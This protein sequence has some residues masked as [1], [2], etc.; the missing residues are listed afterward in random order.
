MTRVSHALVATL[1]LALA[2]PL[3]AAAAPPSS[4]AKPVDLNDIRLPP[5]AKRLNKL[6]MDA[7]GAGDFETAYRE[8]KLSYASMDPRAD[9]DGRDMVLASL[10]SALVKLYEKTG[11]LQH[12]CL[13]RK[14][15]LLHLETL[16]VTFGED[17]DLQDIPGI[18]WRLR[19]I[20]EKISRHSPRLGEPTCN[21]PAIQIVRTAPPPRP[22][23]IIVP[24]PLPLN[25]RGRPALI[26]GATSLSV[27]GVL[28][29]AM[30]YA[31]FMRRASDEGIKAIGAA[32]TMQPDTLPT[33][34]QRALADS[35]AEV[36]RYH[37]TTA[38][39]T[40]IAGGA[41]VLTGVTALIVRRARRGKVS[42]VALHPAPTLTGGSLQLT[43][44]F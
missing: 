42:K 30:T 18:R 13:A 2:W 44:R 40:G 38:L 29:G 31:L 26:V 37:R 14:E 1:T 33:R 28:L 41:L 19:Q 10:R 4:T 20:S 5:E 27:G 39:A 35:L 32:V 11:E 22:K 43:T 36:G 16:L 15:L 8:L 7:Y 21:G 25:D 6:G 34:E 9:I 24:R 17:T 3:H 23:P 12:L